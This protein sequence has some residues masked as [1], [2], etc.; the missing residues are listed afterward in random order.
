M[1]MEVASTTKGLNYLFIEED[2]FYDHA[3]WF[4]SVANPE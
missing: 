3:E 2:L 4:N 1:W